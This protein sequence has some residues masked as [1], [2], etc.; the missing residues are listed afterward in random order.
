[1]SKF[2]SALMAVAVLSV[3]QSAPP[4]ARVAPLFD[5]AS[6]ERSPFPSD[7]FTVPD[8]NQI[9]GRRVNLP[10][11][12]DCTAQ[13]SDCE[14]VAVLNQLD[15]FNLEP[16]ISVPFSGAID[17]ASVDSRSVFL[18][19]LGDAKPE[20]TIGINYVVWDP[21]ARE[22]SFRPDRLLDEHSVYAPV[23]TTAV[24]GA[25]GR[26][27]AAA[28]GYRAE[29]NVRALVPKSADIAVSSVFT[30]QSVSFLVQ[31][32]RDAVRAAPTPRLDF[33]AGTA[34]ERAVFDAADMVVWSN[35]A[36]VSGG[37]PLSSPAVSQALQNMRIVPGVGTVAFGTFRAVDF[38]VHP[39]GHVPVI[40]SRTGSL[41]PTG[42]VTV[43]FNLWLPSG[44]PPA[45]GWPVA[46]CQHGSNA[47][48][49]FCFATTGVL[50]SHRVA[51][52]AINAMGHGGGPRTTMTVGLKSGRSITVAAPGLGYDA[53][54]N[55]QIVTWE[56]FRAARP[57]AILDNSG[58]L[59][60]TVALVLQ[61]VRALQAGVDVD[62]NGT[63]DLD[64]SRI[65]YYGVSL[66]CTYGISAFAV[67]PAIRAAVFVVPPGTMGYNRLLSPP[68]RTRLAL[69]LAERSP[70]L[71]NEAQ[72]L[73]KLDGQ[74]VAP[75][76]FNENLP[77]RDA[78][79]LVNDV[80]GAIAIQRFVDRLAW[81]AQAT[82]SVAAA[83][84]LRR[85][86][87]PGSPP[88][89]F[90]IQAARSDPASTNPAFSALVRAG[91]FADRVAFYRHD[92][93]FGN[94]GVPP[95][96]HQFLGQI[97][98]PPSYSRVARG[99]QEQIATFFESDGKTVMAPTPAELWEMPIKKLPD[100]TF[101]MPRPR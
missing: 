3:P 25:D 93:N 55:G 87:L 62:G 94:D 29:A 43:A 2:I 32:I 67:E 47:A 82:N 59:V 69:M 21:A 72:G 49:N 36:E 33:R 1:M 39:S 30:T 44:T 56:P 28:A 78:P 8:A 24:R 80:S 86:P 92:L 89:P 9:T 84:L 16:R 18:V 31:R 100:D 10:T 64:G 57:F 37:A 79:P 74:D 50:A 40:A 76:L 68:Y 66:G 53:D 71:L 51:V 88:R 98:V 17:P 52:I 45:G 95:G 60:Q 48:K 20:R 46:I 81:A 23:V 91:D 63:P 77:L 11:P 12:K 85:S 38:T 4:A 19:K 5:L 27:I 83:P 14:D 22:L 96:S 7:R 75:P 61:L 41:A 70:S 26:P 99:A 35:N 58:T 42:S 34:G 90:L 65:Y 101:Y 6:L 13:A 54:G 15:G 97:G 73:A